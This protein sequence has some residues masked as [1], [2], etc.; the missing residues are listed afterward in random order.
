MAA[1]PLRERLTPILVRDNA[2]LQ[3]FQDRNSS[4]AEP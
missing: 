3:R 2:A 1:W 4:D